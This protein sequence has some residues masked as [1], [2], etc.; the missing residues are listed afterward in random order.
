MTAPTAA[1]TRPWTEQRRLDEPAYGRQVAYL[2]ER[3]ASRRPRRP[4]VWR[5][6]RSCR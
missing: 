2:L 6:S 1:E 3:S 4:A 5:R